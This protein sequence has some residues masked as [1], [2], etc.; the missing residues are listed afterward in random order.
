[1]R[2]WL[3]LHI[4]LSNLH[5]VLGNSNGPIKKEIG[6]FT[7]IPYGT[8]WQRTLF[9]RKKRGVINHSFTS[10]VIYINHLA[11]LSCWYTK[12]TNGWFQQFMNKIPESFIRFKNF[13]FLSPYSKMLIT[14]L[15]LLQWVQKS[16][17]NQDFKMFTADHDDLWNLAACKN[18]LASCIIY[19]IKNKKHKNRI[20]STFSFHETNQL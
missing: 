12:L 7:F 5:N 1:M 11:M 2:V 8:R 6:W 3:Y 9:D 13:I 14:I 10:V 20:V 4:A 16:L 18:Y 19:N 17:W 15:N